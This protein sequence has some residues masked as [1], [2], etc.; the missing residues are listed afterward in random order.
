MLSKRIIPAVTEKHSFKMKIGMAVALAAS[1]DILLYEHETGWSLAVLAWLFLAVLVAFNPPDLSFRQSRVIGA[2]TLPL[3]LAL[4]EAPSVIP[5]LLI[6]L[7]A[8]A[9]SLP[10]TTAWPGTAGLWLW[11]IL[12]FALQLPA[13]LFIDL[14]RVRE[15]RR[16]RPRARVFNSILRNWA[17]P[18]GVGIIFSVLL[19]QANPVIDSWRPELD[20]EKLLSF[21]HPQRLLFWLTSFVVIWAFLR[22]YQSPQPPGSRFI[23]PALRTGIDKFFSPGAVVRAL[24]LFNLIFLAQTG[25][26]LIYLWSG[27][28]L[29]EGLTYAGY[30]HR[31]AYPLIATALLAGLFTLIAFRNGTSLQNTNFVRHLVFLWIG[32]NIFLTVNAIWRTVSYVEVYGLTYLRIAA[33][34]WMGLVACGLG[35]IICKIAF[36]KSL[37]WLTSVNAISLLAVLFVCSFMNFGGLVADYNVRNSAELGGSG[38]LVDFNYLEEIGPDALPALKLYLREA[39]LKH[40]KWRRAR[41]LAGTLE[42]RLHKTTEDWRGWSFRRQR[43][44]NSLGGDG[45]T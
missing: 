13:R 32:Q 7:S 17:L 21:F 2:A 9:L 34:L 4:V 20:W 18:L 8:I 36:G 45:A 1:S 43:L 15:V 3:T 14:R 5:C 19:I 23:V 10:R 16:K 44:L 11:H 28:S 24:I 39:S 41:H 42:R 30:A 29:P 26:D 6:L 22:R 25:T 12:N 31:G 38:Q 40:V 35:F 27:E 37:Q 33:L